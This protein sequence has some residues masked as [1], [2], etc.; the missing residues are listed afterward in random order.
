MVAE[1]IGRGSLT[2]GG[3]IYGWAAT[4]GINWNKIIECE[5]SSYIGIYMYGLVGT[6]S[7]QICIPLYL[8]VQRYDGDNVKIFAEKLTSLTI[9]VD[10][11]VKIKY[12]ITSDRVKVWLYGWY[13]FL[14]V[15]NE[16][17]ISGLPVVEEPENDAVDLT[18]IG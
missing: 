4:S 1:L 15:G 7:N 16:S 9:N 17:L 12:K 18:I 11:G 6:F 3:L 13:S 5:A 14:S 10:Y 2:K 8:R